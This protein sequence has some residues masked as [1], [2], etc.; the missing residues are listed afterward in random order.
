MSTTPGIGLSGKVA[1]RK[2]RPFGS[3]RLRVA[4]FDDYERIAAL[5][6]RN[7][8]PVKSRE[9]WLALWSRNPVFRQANG[10]WP[11]GT[12]LETQTGDIAGFIAN[13]PAAFHFRGRQLR[14]AITGSWVVDP[15]YRGCSM[16]LL[17]SVRSRKESIC[18]LRTPPAQRQ[19]RRCGSCD[20]PGC[21]REYG[22]SRTSG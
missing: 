2:N 11:I 16:I 17:N 22:T 5:Q 8:F 15:A 9:E 14:G 12:V 3:P 21:R 19:S 13:I 10:K 1:V 20:G 6:I 18:L 4:R 7:D